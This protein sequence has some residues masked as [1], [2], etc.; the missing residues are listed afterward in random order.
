MTVVIEY[1]LFPCNYSLH[2]YLDNACTIYLDKDVILWCY[3]NMHLPFLKEL[4]GI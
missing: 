3:L 4:H 2:M 1:K